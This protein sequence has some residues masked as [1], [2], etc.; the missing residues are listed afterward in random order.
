MDPKLISKV[1]KDCRSICKKLGTY[2]AL[3]II[4]YNNLCISSIYDRETDTLTTVN[5]TED[6]K[7]I[8]PKAVEAVQK[9]Y[10]KGLYDTVNVNNAIFHIFFKVYSTRPICLALI[11]T[12]NSILT[13]IELDEYG[14]EALEKTKIFKEIRE[15]LMS[16]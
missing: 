7:G 1:L 13:P 4:Y 11:M 14:S 2:M 5:V 9:K 16:M 8:D 10:R 12:T 6:D 3:A 15:Y